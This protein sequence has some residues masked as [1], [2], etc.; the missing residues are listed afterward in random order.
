MRERMLRGE[1]YRADDPEL[2]ALRRRAHAL[3]GA[4]V[5][6]EPETPA[7]DAALRALLGSVGDGVVVRPTLRVDYGAHITIGARSFVNF[8]CV[9][10][11]VCPIVLGA[12]C[13][14]GPRV[15]L[16]T[17]THPLDAAERRSGWEAGA[18]ITVGDDVWL[19]AGATVLP[20]VTIGPRT[21]VGAG[22]VVTRDLPA[23]VVAIGAPAR[24]VR[25]LRP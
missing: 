17:A 18:P 4:L 2:D 20:G 10:L 16:I 22:A 3:S 11:D 24:V 21:V 13:Q 14:L 1:P 25:E 19:G 15:Q 5:R 12:D 7:A 8:D 9:L 6:C 23:D